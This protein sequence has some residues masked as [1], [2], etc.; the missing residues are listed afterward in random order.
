MDQNDLPPDTRHLKV[1]SGV[2]KMI[3][4]PMVHLAQTMHLSSVEI[5]TIQ[6]D[7]NELPV[8]PRHQEVPSAMPKMISPPVVHSQKPCS[9]LA[10]R[11]A[12]SPNR[13]KRAFTWPTSPRSM[14]G[15]VQ[16][17]FQDYGTF[18]ANLALSCAKTNTTSKLSETSFHLTY[19]T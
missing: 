5:N 8:D 13:P 11:L 15:C 19:I 3:S 1:P 10:P 9:Y 14:I 4:M 16:N 12:L 17:N 6:I 18:G 2:P 7:Q